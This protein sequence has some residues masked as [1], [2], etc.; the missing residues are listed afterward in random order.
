MTTHA[1]GKGACTERE[2]GGLVL[3]P[4]TEDHGLPSAMVVHLHYIFAL[5][6]GP[7]IYVQN[8]RIVSSYN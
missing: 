8:A 1:D 2:G 5:L 4:I 3:G 7:V 6:Q